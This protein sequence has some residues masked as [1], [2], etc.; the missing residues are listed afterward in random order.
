MAGVSKDCRG[1]RWPLAGISLTPP[2]RDVLVSAVTA[3]AETGATP[4]AAIMGALVAEGVDPTSREIV[5]NVPTVM[6]MLEDFIAG[7]LRFRL[8]QALAE[9]PDA[10]IHLVGNFPDVVPALVARAREPGNI[11]VHGFLR[12]C[13][14]GC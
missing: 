9:L 8:A 13:P 11:T 1:N 5:D 3:V 7:K 2:F 4:H 10:R 14:V 6:V 12:A